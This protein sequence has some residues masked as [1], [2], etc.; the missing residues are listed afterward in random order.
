[1]RLGGK[2]PASYPGTTGNEATSSPGSSRCP[3]AASILEARRP[4]DEVGNEAGS[5]KPEIVLSI[6]CDTEGTYGVR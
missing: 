5:K 4:W 2:N 6:S 1:M 3:A